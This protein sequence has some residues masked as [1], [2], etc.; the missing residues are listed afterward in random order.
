MFVF[1]LSIEV[2]ASTAVELK[3]LLLHNFQQVPKQSEAML[4]N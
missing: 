1:S 4:F 2:M 3:I